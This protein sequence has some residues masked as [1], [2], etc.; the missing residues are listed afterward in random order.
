MSV[1]NMLYNWQ[2]MRLMGANGVAVFGVIMYVNFIFLAI[3]LG[4]SIGSAPIVGYHY[5][6]GNKDE[7]QG[8]L[9][10]SLS[11]TAVFSIILTLAALLLARPLS[12][13][14]MSHDAPL[15]LQSA[16]FR[17]PPF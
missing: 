17:L 16:Y 2:L 13:L 14:F 9:R 6:A 7:L 12:A 10:K 4:Y 11:L 8:L 5:G 1:V 15:R 3:F